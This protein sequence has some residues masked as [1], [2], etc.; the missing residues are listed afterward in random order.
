MSG[1]HAVLLARGLATAGLIYAAAGPVTAFFR[2]EEARWAFEAIAVVPLLKGLMHLD[3]RRRQRHLDNRP[4]MICETAPQILALLAAWPVL[5]VSGSYAAAVWIAVVQSATALAASHMLARCPYR[6]AVTKEI[7]LRVVKFGWPIWLS[8]FPLIA[9]Y[10]VDRAI[11]GR[12]FGMETLAGYSAAF[13]L[14]MVPATIAGRAA[15]ALM[16][17]LLVEVREF[18]GLFRKRYGVMAE[19]YIIA[20]A[21]YSA[22]A[23]IAGDTL[24]QL[25]FGTRYAGLGWVISWLG[26]MWALRMVQAV[27]G[28]SLLS[29]GRTKPLLYAG[30]V[31]ASALVVA[32]AAAVGGFGVE[33]VAAAGVLGEIASIVY[34][35]FASQ[36]RRKSDP[37]GMTWLFLT[38]SAFLF[39]VFAFS[40]LIALLM[41]SGLQSVVVLPVAAV[42]AVIVTFAGLALFP[43]ARGLAEM[44]WQAVAGDRTGRDGKA[45]A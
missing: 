33:G 17:P 41:P 31:R 39:P 28:M 36:G 15:H 4:F 23:I 5:A 8:A 20:A 43:G 30:L 35:A 6:I 27:P 2:I 16:L 32:V 38:R 42:T 29:M 7:L 3:T 1:L 34:V 25:A 9:V 11:V 14:T 45:P 19:I 24:I 18:K 22:V 40:G 21:V 26:V 37:R 44:G 13:M 10:Y 12:M